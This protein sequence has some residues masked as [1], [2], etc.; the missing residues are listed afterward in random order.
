MTQGGQTC[1]ASDIAIGHV[2]L[3]VSDLERAVTFYREVLAFEVQ[4][5]REGGAYVAMGCY[6][7]HLGLIGPSQGHNGAAMARCAAAIRYP[8][9]RALAGAARRRPLTV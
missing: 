1:G 8:T 2:H 7:H 9:W 5:M 6:H 3:T 4:G